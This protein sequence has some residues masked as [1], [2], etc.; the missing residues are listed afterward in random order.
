MNTVCTHS[1][2]ANGLG[3]HDTTAEM[4]EKGRNGTNYMRIT[5]TM[6]QRDGGRWTKV[7]TYPSYTSLVF[8]NDASDHTFGQSFLWP[9]R[10]VD[11]GE[12]M[13]WKIKFVWY[14]QR[15]GP[16][17]KLAT[18]FKTSAPCTA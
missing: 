2:S 18:K 15:P 1:G 5:G 14:D 10:P 13:R 17:R 7:H 12:T 16:D 4:K 3:T 8:P 6:Q 9:F 11:V